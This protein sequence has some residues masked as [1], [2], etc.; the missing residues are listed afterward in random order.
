MRKFNFASRPLNTFSFVLLPLFPPKF[1]SPPLDFGRKKLGAESAYYNNSDFF[2]GFVRGKIF[3]SKEM[4]GV[5]SFL[6]ANLVKIADFTAK[7]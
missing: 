1:Y 7:T 2:G 4:S 3:L 6:S 5:K